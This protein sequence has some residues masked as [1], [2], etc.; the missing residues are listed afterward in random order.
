MTTI[1][2][3]Q[4]VI[5][6]LKGK[7]NYPK[8]YTQRQLYKKMYDDARTTIIDNLHSTTGKIVRGRLPDMGCDAAVSRYISVLACLDLAETLCEQNCDDYAYEDLDLKFNKIRKVMN[9]R[10]EAGIKDA[11]KSWK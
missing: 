8:D 7:P 3:Q 6:I 4:E 10:I 5:D 1:D 2:K 11:E 9:T